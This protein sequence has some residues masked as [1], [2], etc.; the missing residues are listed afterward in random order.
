MLCQMLSSRLYR[1]CSL[2][3]LTLSV[4]WTT[5]PF[6]LQLY[7]ANY[8]LSNSWWCHPLTVTMRRVTASW[9]L[10]KNAMIFDNTKQKAKPYPDI[11][12]IFIIS[13][14]M[15]KLPWFLHVL[16]DSSE[17]RK[18][19]SL[20]VVYT[21]CWLQSGKPLLQWGICKYFVAS[22]PKHQN[23]NFSLP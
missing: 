9:F 13:K 14:Q 7:L 16:A 20:L 11:T 8:K 3:S 12:F 6:N 22:F 23:R 1:S 10:V 18:T 5:L 15:F 4:T 21:P 2:V 19:V 17:V